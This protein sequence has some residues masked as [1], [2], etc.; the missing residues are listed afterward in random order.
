VDAGS[1]IAGLASDI[2]GDVRPTGTAYDIG[3]DEYTALQSSSS[4]SKFIQQQLFQLKF[5]VLEQLVV[6]FQQLKF[7]RQQ[8]VQFIQQQLKLILVVRRQRH[9]QQFFRR[10]RCLQRMLPLLARRTKSPS[11]DDETF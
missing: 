11:L 4:S 7:V 6:G 9:R 5:I 8:V 3:A 10:W 2:D 1:F